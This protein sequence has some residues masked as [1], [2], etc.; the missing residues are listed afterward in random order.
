MAIEAGAFQIRSAGDRQ[1]QRRC[2]RAPLCL[3]DSRDNDS[4]SGRGC[5]GAV[6]GCE[7]SRTYSGVVHG[8]R[9]LPREGASCMVSAGDWHLCGSH[10]L[11][12][13]WMVA[14]VGSDG[15][16]AWEG[17]RFF[18]RKSR[19]FR[20]GSGSAF[21]RRNLLGDVG[22]ESSSFL[23]DYSG[24]NCPA[25]GIGDGDTLGVVTSLEVSFEGPFPLISNLDDL[26][27]YAGAFGMAMLAGL[28]GGEWMHPSLS[29]SPSPT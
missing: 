6:G 25:P 14:A 27:S 15:D 7:G 21:W 16:V 23:G 9:L 5:G 12:G 18:G 29:P 10:A 20:V 13:F 8:L 28:R 22:V 4:G 1:W 11:K 24:E 26:S 17:Q 2:G 3:D 19:L